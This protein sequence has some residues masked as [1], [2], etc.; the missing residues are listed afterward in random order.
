MWRATRRTPKRALAPKLCEALTHA[1]GMKNEQIAIVALSVFA[2]LEF[3]CIL[4]LGAKVRAL[5]R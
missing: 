3:V 1:R 5:K 2:V 4:S